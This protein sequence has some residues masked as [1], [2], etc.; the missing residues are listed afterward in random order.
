[1]KKTFHSFKKFLQENM[2]R[3]TLSIGLGGFSTLYI[4]FM[5]ESHLIP[6]LESLNLFDSV[7][8]ETMNV[9]LNI[10][11]MLVFII[12][13]L[14]T[15]VSPLLWK[16]QKNTAFK[17]S[18]LLFLLFLVATTGFIM[19]ISARISSAFKISVALLSVYSVWIAIDILRIIYSWLMIEKSK[20]VQLDVAKLTFLW[21]IIV[22]IFGIM[23]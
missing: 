1:M 3:I 4:I 11:E 17:V 6:Y 15:L 23:K 22:F 5:C 2:G 10:P 12:S 14:C 8:L 20:S 21:A 16:K 9:N 18:M 13:L 19:V 7:S